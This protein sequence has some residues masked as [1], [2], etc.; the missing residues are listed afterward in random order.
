MQWWN[1]LIRA[2]EPALAVGTVTFFWIGLCCEA[3][4]PTSR[5]ASHSEHLMMDGGYSPGFPVLIDGFPDRPKNLEADHGFDVV[6][7]LG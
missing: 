4:I 7:G 1:G 5:T 3:L 2:I 6:Q